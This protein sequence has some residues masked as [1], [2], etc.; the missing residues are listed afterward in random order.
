MGHILSLLGPAA[1]NEPRIANLVIYAKKVENII[2]EM[3]ENEHEYFQLLSE[4]C[5]KI[6]KD[7]EEARR[8][9]NGTAS[10]SGNGSTSSLP[11]HSSGSVNGMKLDQT[12][13]KKWSREELLRHFKQL[14]ENI[15]QDKNAE[16]FR[17]PVDPVALN[18]PDYAEIIKHPMDLSTIRNNLEDG[19]YKDPWQVLD[20][21]RLMFQ[22]AWLYNK[23]NSKVYKM[24]TKV[25]HISPLLLYLLSYRSCLKV[26]WTKSCRQWDFAVDTSILISKFFTAVQQTYVGL[27]KMPSITYMQIS[28]S[29]ITN[30]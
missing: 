24:C 20:H 1:Y 27:K 10:A 17:E 30:W 3:A 11:F 25:I 22:N 12:K 4:R 9:R 6:Y 16:C 5:R 14:H 13:W 29:I 26:K 2:F 28:E 8:P 18:M 23:K 19:V 15:C 7:L 21:Y